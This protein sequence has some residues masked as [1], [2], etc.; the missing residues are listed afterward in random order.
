MTRRKIFDPGEKAADVHS[1]LGSQM[2]DRASAGAARPSRARL[3]GKPPE[4]LP[5]LAHPALARS[6]ASQV[7]QMQRQRGNGYVQA[8]LGVINMPEEVIT[9]QPPQPGVINMPEEVIT[10]QP[11]QPGVINMPEQVI[12]AKPPQPDVINMPEE[13]ITARPP[14]PGVIVMP[15]ETITARSPQPGEIDIPEDVITAK[16]PQPGVIVMPE[17]TIT[18]KP[19]GPGAANMQA[20]ID[21]SAGEPARD[22]APPTEP[23]KKAPGGGPPEMTVDRDKGKLKPVGEPA[24][25]GAAPGPAG[26][27]PAAGGAPAGGV[28]HWQGK[29]KRATLKR[30]KSPDMGGVK[31][32]PGKL[33]GQGQS[34][35]ASRKAAQPDY[36]QE[37]LKNIPKTPPPQGEPPLQVDPVQ[38]ATDKRIEG[39]AARRLSDQTMPALT[40]SP[41]HPKI[42]SPEGR[43]PSL[44]PLPP[45]KPQPEPPKPDAPASVPV[46]EKEKEQ[47]KAFQDKLDKPAEQKTSVAPPPA[48]TLKDKGPPSMK[49]AS[50][51]LQV[52]ISKALARLSVGAQQEAQE[53]VRDA[54]KESYPRDALKVVAPKI[55]QDEQGPE[56]E[57]LEGELQGIRQAA[58]VS[59]SLLDEH[60]KQERT[61]TQETGQQAGAELKKTDE[62]AK[63]QTEQRGKQAQM[64][65]Q[66]GKQ[67]VKDTLAQ[68]RAAAGQPPDPKYIDEKKASLI[69]QIEK[70]AGRAKAV[71]RL[72]GEKRTGELADAGKRQSGAYKLTSQQEAQ[73]IRAAYTEETEGRVQAR[74]S[75]N[76]GD[77]RALF[78]EGEVNRLKRSAEAQVETFQGA[79]PMMSQLA[80]ESVRQWAAD[81]LGKK[82]SFWDRL[83]DWLLDIFRQSEANTQAWEQ[84]RNR[85]TKDQMVADFEMLNKVRDAIVAK[86]ADE[87]KTTLASLSAEQRLILTIF[88]TSGG[89]SVAAVAAG[90]FLAMKRRHTPQLVEKF[91][92]E[93]LKLEE[94][95][96]LNR[97]GAA[98]SR[99][100]DALQIAAEIRASVK[101]MGTKE[102]RLFKALGRRTQ[103]QVKAIEKA[104]TFKYQRNMREDVEDEF[105]ET[106]SP[107]ELKRARAALAA[108]PVGDDVFRLHDA[109]D[110]IN[111]DEAAVMT[112]LRNK[113]PAERQEIIA[114]YKREYNVDLSAHLKKELDP[115][116]LQ[117]AQALMA[118]DV[119]K[120]DAVAV[121]EGLRRQWFGKAETMDEIYTRIRK[122]VEDSAEAR[123]MSTAEVEAEIKRRTQNLEKHFNQAFAGGKP[124]GL[125]QAFKEELDEPGQKLADALA[126]N[127]PT[128]ADAARLLIERQSFVTDD[129]KVNAVLKAQG[130]R[131]EKE[132]RRDLMLKFRE[133]AAAAAASGKPWTEKEFQSKL[134]AVN[135]E[136]ERQIGERS[137]KYMQGL[138]KAYDKIDPLAGFGPGGLNV[139]I[140]FNMSGNDRLKAKEL[141][142]SGGRLTPAQEVFFAVY[143]LGTDDQALRNTLKDKSPAEIAAI[144]KDYNA[145]YKDRDFD[146]DVMGEA[147]GGREQHDYAK[148]LK[149][150]PQTP[151]ERYQQLLA[152]KAFELGSGSGLGS[153]FAG[154]ETEVLGRMTGEAGKA[155]QDYQATLKAKG[156][157]DPETRKKLERF[158]SIAGAGER[159]VEEFREAVDSITDA[160]ATVAAIVVGIAVAVATA[161]TASPAVIAALSA[162]AGAEA[163]IATKIAMKG[164]SYGMEDLGGDLAL[165]GV[166]VALA[167][168]TAGVGNAMLRSGVLS[169]L[170][171]GQL[172]S[173]V[174]AHGLAQGAENLV[175]ALPSGLLG[176]L[177]SDQTWAEGNDRLQA[178]LMGLVQ[179]GGMA[180]GMG[181]GIGG[182]HGIKPP[183]GV[184]PGAPKPSV[185]PPAG[186]KAGEPMPSA[187]KVEA[188]PVPEPKVE[189]PPEVNKGLEGKAEPPPSQPRPEPKKAV[190]P[191][192]PKAEAEP[193][194]GEPAPGV[195]PQETP[196]IPPEPAALEPRPGAAEAASK[197]EM[198]TSGPKPEQP[199]K[200]WGE[201]KDA[202]PHHKQALPE[203]LRSEV[204]VKVDP[205]IPGDSVLVHY[206]IDPKTGLVTNIRMRI[207]P[208]TTAEMISAH[209]RTVRMMQ[210]YAGFSGRVLE[211]FRRFQQW[212]GLNG[213]PK[214]GTLAWEAHLEVDKLP[215]IIRKRL[216]LLNAGGLDEDA[217]AR[218]IAELM[219][220]QSQLKHHEATLKS[221]ETSPGVGFVAVLRDK[222]L[223][224]YAAAIFKNSKDLPA[225]FLEEGGWKKFIDEY[226]FAKVGEK[227][228]LRKIG[229]ESDLALRYDL[230]HPND[231]SKAKIEKAEDWDV[232]WSA[233]KA[234]AAAEYKE[235]LAD[236]PEFEN[237]L[238]AKRAPDA[239]VKPGEPPPKGWGDEDVAQI[240]KWGKVVQK[241]HAEMQA[242]GEVPKDF[243][244]RL[245]NL[246]GLDADFGEAAY[247]RFRH[248]VRDQITGLIAS[249]KEPAE[250]RRLL[251]AFLALQPDPKSKGEQFSAFRREDLRSLEKGKIE[252]L[253]K[254]PLTL[255]GDNPSG[256]TRI[257]DGVVEVGNLPEDAAPPPGKYLVDDKS[258][259]GAFKTDQADDYSHQLKSGNGKVKAGGHSYD[260]IV[261]FFDSETAA[262]ESRKYMGPVG[263]KGS[264]HENI[265]IGYY[266]AN[267][268]LQW[269]PR[270]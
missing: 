99:G 123:N 97:L 199:L 208:A 263:K 239:P 260:G 211:V 61:K 104:Y 154:E 153:L 62:Q 228:H 89:D 75:L 76:W 171:E 184:K 34:L 19:P 209:V 80:K 176:V 181:F 146:K 137:Q 135:K 238:K 31:A 179:S 247:S 47:K 37:A 63:K 113:T 110:R 30:V 59:K 190:E 259:T 192:A 24:A 161:G 125:Q 236:F 270:E 206:D 8:A 117:Q 188:P 126:K 115:I 210:R 124:G 217:E 79:L 253:E 256:K 127:D 267:G 33:A 246:K 93:S 27:S 86:N 198:H 151:A 43:Y 237:A 269:L 119:D 175:G 177:L 245:L 70:G 20:Q 128:Q 25:T 186:V 92:Q 16:P 6:R 23:V 196:Q 26:G 17:E 132:V 150:K 214:P 189:L 172:V 233:R 84:E 94:W 91:R 65:I 71:Y 235:P 48:E 111:T 56:K 139:L 118:G 9:A 83:I 197:A 35:D 53:I 138:T 96:D 193:R 227:Y 157:D 121:Q 39:F 261:Y 222:E 85:A 182:L 122:E 98:Q 249:V 234:R 212:I 173:R 169:R 242:R 207:G 32:S 109:L 28:Q 77:E 220:L 46:R 55:A 38:K 1:A 4:H 18:V 178:V 226:Y 170:A 102:E 3:P 216:A 195:K 244:D 88:F 168:M 268:R 73:E 255:D 112:V 142:K 203:R 187:P 224:P 185:E 90:L 266:D 232:S 29:V 213:R 101:G 167:A 131:A 215:R 166:D 148:L 51:E 100:F 120:A 218:L 221:M 200:D 67:T 36:K 82:R 257:A 164:H 243:F 13:V 144:R 252:P 241:L 7:Q 165:A 68:K 254:L 180:L 69:G 42:R 160:A 136:A 223:E 250:R 105:S 40:R 202:A 60:V 14:Q 15:E 231:L 22:G 230:D 264:L 87:L 240:R 72:A 140:E 163:G 149:G 107:D 21:K 191:A 2:P 158:N 45:P 134:Q 54:E 41:G 162:A 103:V 49:P 11:P 174:A 133:E 52:D 106:F 183:K 265:Y 204:P 143:D 229:G 130:D 10:A 58:G 66:A 44:I 116:E 225:R 159:S 108:D 78:V 205:D 145:R 57:K 12:T 95:Y 64:E 156:P 262:K 194:P 147:W 141:V 258:G 248:A 129:G 219:D 155:Y 251:D 114:R 81:Q 201:L 5:A 74:P 152:D 50:A